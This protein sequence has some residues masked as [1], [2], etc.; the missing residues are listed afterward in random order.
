MNVLEKMLCSFCLQTT[1]V[2]ACLSKWLDGDALG[3]VVC[4]Q[5]LQSIFSRTCAAS[6]VAVM[7]FWPKLGSL[8]RGKKLN[9][10]VTLLQRPN[11]AHSFYCEP[12]A[13]AMSSVLGSMP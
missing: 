12:A 10:D 3:T 4:K 9:P 8:F 7:H 13:R 1:V 6:L 5:K 11:S 2:G